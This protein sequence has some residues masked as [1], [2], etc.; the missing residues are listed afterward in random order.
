MNRERFEILAEAY[1]GDVS[2][3]P[4]DERDAAAALMSADAG[5][6]LEVLSRAGDLD[7]ALAAFA[8]VRGAAGLAER[9]VAG[10]PEARGRRWITWL[11]PA[12]MGA[13]LAAACAAGVMAGA[14]L[15]TGSLPAND[16]DAVVS[17]AGDDDF[18][19]DLED[20][21]G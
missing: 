3:W 15:F 5:W 10:A 8:P 9:I 18:G 6:A 12:G 16:S 4:T 1:G 19:L 20:A 11:L 14:H 21:A 2:R 13:G 17:V 7:A